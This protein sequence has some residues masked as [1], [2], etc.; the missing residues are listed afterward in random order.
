MKYAICIAF[1]LLSMGGMEVQ[2]S[3]AMF[4]IDTAERFANLSLARATNPHPQ[5]E[6]ATLVAAGSWSS[7]L[8]D[9]PA[10]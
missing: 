10:V 1:W 9:D 4:D 3:T 5:A 2:N 7:M 6:R 8:G